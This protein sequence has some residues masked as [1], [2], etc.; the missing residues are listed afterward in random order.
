MP[1]DVANNV[2]QAAT[3]I[4]TADNKL[5]YSDQAL[6]SGQEAIGATGAVSSELQALIGGGTLTYGDVVAISRS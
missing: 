3:I 4:I 5:T 2:A 1:I 6:T